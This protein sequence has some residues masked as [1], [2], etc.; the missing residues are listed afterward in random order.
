MHPEPKEPAAPTN[1][2]GT[3]MRI[4]LSPEKLEEMQRGKSRLEARRRTGPIITIPKPRAITPTGGVD[5]QQLFQ[6]IYDAAIITDLNGEIVR[7][8]VRANQ[9][10][11]AEPG[12]LMHDSIL[13]LICTASA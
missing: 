1:P 5:F 4:D 8:N 3:T 10:F 2:F 9:F 6:N 12:Q 13:A 7:V 11:I